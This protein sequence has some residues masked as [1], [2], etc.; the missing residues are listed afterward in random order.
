MITN[1][2]YEALRNFCR[3][4]YGDIPLLLTPTTY[5]FPFGTLLASQ[6]ITQSVQINANCDFILLGLRFNGNGSTGAEASV[7]QIT[8]S[9]NSNTLFNVP[10]PVQVPGGFALVGN[11]NGASF[12]YPYWVGANTGII[13]QLTSVDPAA[14]PLTNSVVDLVGFH[15]RELI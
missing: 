2:S 10:I 11:D 5:Q 14:D 8:D 15:V 4:I 7:L 6:Q 13:G 1:F 3:K 9:S 12:H